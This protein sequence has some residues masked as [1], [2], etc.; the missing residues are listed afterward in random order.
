MRI[1]KLAIEEVNA[2]RSWFHPKDRSVIMANNSFIE[3]EETAT[4]ANPSHNRGRLYWKNGCWTQLDESGSEESL[5]N[6]DWQ[7]WPPTLTQSG[8]VTFTIT[9][10]RYK[11][12]GN[13]IQVRMRLSVTG[14]GTAG[15]AIIVGG[16]PVSPTVAS[17]IFGVMRV[18]DTSVSTSYV[19]A[20][21][22]QS[23]T[24]AAGASP[25]AALIG[26]NPSLA[27]ATGDLVDIVGTYER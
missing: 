8:A 14:S 17:G 7:N 13:T 24:S 6:A 2:L 16:L 21:Q 18:F 19:G 1:Y 15:S 12:D 22:F 27:L 9:F 23:T 5:C 20:L 4:P 10:A 26:N 25:S 3:G 11:D